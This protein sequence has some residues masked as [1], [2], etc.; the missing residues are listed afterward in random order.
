[1]VWITYMMIDDSDTYNLVIEVCKKISEK[2]S[3]FRYSAYE[4]IM[5]VMLFSDSKDVAYKRGTWFYHKVSKKLKF[6]VME[7][8]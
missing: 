6:K 5:V 3:S 2:D 8:S 7:V 4:D 1:M